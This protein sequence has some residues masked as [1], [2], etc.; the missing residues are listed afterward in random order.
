MKA[1]LLK[2]EY[3][4]Y[5]SVENGTK[6]HEVRLNDRDF[7]I[8]DL[9]VLARYLGPEKGFSGSVMSFFISEVIDL[10]PVG[11]VGWC[12]FDLLE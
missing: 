9:V 12:S 10:A 5:D 4:Y 7:Q 6:T 1:H 8:G 2:T 11:L 3:R